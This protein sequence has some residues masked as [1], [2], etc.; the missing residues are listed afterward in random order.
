MFVKIETEMAKLAFGVVLILMVGG[1]VDGK[2]HLTS[3]NF[4][5]DYH[6]NWTNIGKVSILGGFA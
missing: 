2:K 4:I 3:S 1:L 5:L 6:I